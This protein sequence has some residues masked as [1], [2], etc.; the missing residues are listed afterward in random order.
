MTMTSTEAMDLYNLAVTRSDEWIDAMLCEWKYVNELKNDAMTDRNG[1]VVAVLH[2]LS[3]TILAEIRHAES[4][5]TGVLCDII[6]DYIAPAMF[7]EYTPGN[8]AVWSHSALAPRPP[9]SL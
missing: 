3:M 1:E 8:V 7:I 4:I 9:V 5:T 2:N 6:R